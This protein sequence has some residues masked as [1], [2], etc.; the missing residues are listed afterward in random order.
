[1]MKTVMNILASLVVIV[2]FL[3]STI[4]AFATMPAGAPR[5]RKERENAV[6]RFIADMQG[7]IGQAGGKAGK[8]VGQGSASVY[9]AAGRGT[10]ELYKEMGRAC[11]EA[12]EGVGRFCSKSYQQVLGNLQGRQRQQSP[13]IHRRQ[14]APT[15]RRGRR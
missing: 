2:L 10:A 6:F 15:Q 4:S 12:G 1:M 3:S 8:S 11:K 7:R 13:P 14:Y 9:K 5:S